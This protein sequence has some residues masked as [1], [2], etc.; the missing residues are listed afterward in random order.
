MTRKI[1]KL[2]KDFGISSFN[3]SGGMGGGVS[4]EDPP[5]TTKGDLSGFDTTFARIPVGVDGQVVTADSTVP[6]GL[7]WE[8]AG[9]GIEY[10]QLTTATTFTPTTQTGLVKVTVDGTDVTA[11]S[12]DVKVDGSIIENIP[13]ATFENRIVN[14]STSLS[15]V[16]TNEIWSISGASY[17]SISFDP[18]S[19]EGSPRGVAFN[20]DGTKMYVL[21]AIN[22][23]VYQYTL[24]TAWNISTASYDSVSFSVNAEET[25]PSGIS[26]KSDGTKMY[27]IGS[28]SDTVFQYSLSTA[29]DMSTSS[30]D[31]V[32]FSVASQAIVPLALAFEP[33]GTKMYVIDNNTNTIYQYSITANFA[34]TARISVG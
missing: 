19:E 34:G 26:F 33:N 27:I 23:T 24:S 21:G 29:W 11:G 31:G 5:T 20:S 1:K 25:S 10:S 22:K 28:T 32:S 13:F 9:G 14:P 4:G 6:L 2:I 17:D 12:I 18:T 7:A 16:S 30:Y 15:L 3:Y 8:T